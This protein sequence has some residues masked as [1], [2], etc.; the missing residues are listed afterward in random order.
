MIAL[1]AAFSV[2]A[3]A[4]QSPQDV[5]ALRALARDG[6]DSVLVER[7]RR[8]PRDLREALRQ[9]LAAAARSE[10]SVGLAALTAA[11][12]LA[13]ASV[14]AWRDSFYVRKVSR[15]RA[16][17]PADRQSNVTADSALRVGG[18]AL[19]SAGVD[20]AMPAWRESLRLY[21]GLADSAGIARALV[22]MAGGFRRASS[23]DSAEAY[24]RRCRDLAERIRDY[25]TLGNVI[26]QQAAMKVERGDLGGAEELLAQ[27]KLSLE[28]TGDPIGLA[29]TQNILGIVARRRGDLAGARRAFEAALAA[30]RSGG[31][32][33]GAAQILNNLG[34]LAMGAG[35][36]AEAAARYGEALSTY[37]KLGREPDAADVLRNLAVLAHR[38]GDYP[39]ALRAD[40]E[41]LGISRRTGPE[42]REVDVRIQLS[43]TR[44]EMGDLQSAITELDRAEALARH[45]GGGGE[46]VAR[47]A[48]A[49]GHLAFRLN[50][51]ADAERE[52]ARA[53]RLSRG[54]GAADVSTR[55][56]AQLGMADVLLKRAS[57]REAQ[58]T[59]ERVLLRGEFDLHNAAMTRT[60][61]GAAA[62]RAGDTAT[63]RR[64]F[65]VAI[66][67][68]RSIGAVD[69]EAKAL[70]ELGDFE[71][72]A[73]RALVAE[74]L[75][76]RG[77]TRLGAR[78][79]PEIARDLHA[80]LAG[81]LRSQ[82]ALPEAAQEL[83][84]AIANIERVS[85][86]LPLEEHR[87]AFR[88][89]K[90]NVYVELA[91]VERARGRTEAAFEASERLRE[92]QLLELLAR[93][94]VTEGPTGPTLAGREQDLR[95]KIGE[96]TQ[97]LEARDDMASELRDPARPHPATE[98]TRAE[99]TEAQEAYGALLTEMRAANPAYAALVRGEIAPAAAVKAALAP[100]EALLEYLVGD[101]TTIVFVV[102][103]DSLVA[104]D[105]HLTH[106]AL[107]ARLDFARG[108]LASP[109]AGAARSA[110]RSPL[111]RLY[112]QLI[113]PVEASGLLA[114]KQRLLIA[115]HAELHYLPFAALLRPGPPEQL[116][117][118]RYVL[119]YVPSASVWLRLRERP[120][121]P[122]SGHV[123]A[124]APRATALPGSQAE[125]TAIGRAYGDRAQALLGAAATEHAF[126]TLA[127]GQ[128]IVHLATYGVLNKNNPLFSFVELGA[129]DGDDG[130]LEVHEVFG[131]T[132]NARL[133]VLSACQTGL[134]SGAVADVPPGDDWV[135]L[136]QGFL[137]AGASNVI[138]TLWPVADIA[139]ARFMEG[140]YHELAAGRPEAEALALAQRAALRNPRTAHPFFWAG[141]TLVSGE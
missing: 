97:R 98:A 30:N 26:T 8:G 110:W 33:G 74:S 137:Y 58:V 107:I 49:R 134:G 24:L 25:S 126:R 78:P 46:W 13:S 87:A 16:L 61:M 133:V 62:W 60:L 85:G 39:A 80:G 92:R 70:S 139:T 18:E 90:W 43:D 20:A 123:L 72:N 63:A 6:P 117:I 29:S 53:Q 86:N 52:Y 51:L 22:A 76:R 108:T 79:A 101:S 47:I 95:R 37:R 75:Y 65:R 21:E 84:S 57:Y 19:N 32:E 14:V 105:L 100:D 119:E 111:R 28:R 9:L 122:R 120:A 5:G 116:L 17:S 35:D 59:L 129:G 128:E 131:L 7:L 71:A 12:R 125:V 93:G 136:V 104:L 141:F 121:P 36:Y 56:R 88:A 109:T 68:L 38:R 91:L 48:L 77:L 140:F 3:L 34:T 73:G 89:D 23:D 138:G 15:F 103:S 45:R 94:R 132:L 124:F 127:P 96:L 50:R 4:A 11:E 135:G 81:A 66:D 40:S 115:P 113:A 118:E 82:G 10:D 27:A 1:T 42:S 106:D 112:Q 83:L 102:T 2:L 114:G 130:R 31:N 67:T 64:A 54:A 69:E 99:L 44:A 41:A 55:N